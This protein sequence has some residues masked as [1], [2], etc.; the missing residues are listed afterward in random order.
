MTSG[1]STAR[2]G[3]G[4]P[5]AS[6]HVARVKEAEQ[7]LV[8]HAID[9]DGPADRDETLIFGVGFAEIVAVEPFG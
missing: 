8:H 3:A 1:I 2:P 6:S 9:T 7:H 5:A 4:C